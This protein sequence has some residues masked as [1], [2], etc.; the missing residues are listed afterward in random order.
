MAKKSIKIQTPY[1][2]PDQVY[3]DS[4]KLAIASGIEVKLM[5]PKIP[6]KKLVYNAS[7]SYVRELVELGAKV[8]LFKGFLHAKT[9][10]IDDEICTIGTCNSDNRSFYLN[11]EINAFIYNE[12]FTQT[13]LKSIENDIKN[14]IEFKNSITIPRF[15]RFKMAL[16]RLFT[17]LL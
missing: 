5:I 17:P 8:Y 14:S 10:V 11:F 6:D 9:M 4:L 3:L 7:L 2:V 16:S 15:R 1:F 12:E 13:V